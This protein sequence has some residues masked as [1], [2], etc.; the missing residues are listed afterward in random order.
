MGKKHRRNRQYQ[1]GQQQFQPSDNPQDQGEVEMQEDQVEDPE[2]SEPEGNDA[3]EV[4]D[5]ATTEPETI[6]VEE[7]VAPA[8][9]GQDV[10]IPVEVPP[11][12]HQ[13]QEQVPTPAPAVP[14]PEPE[15]PKPVPPASEVAQQVSVQPAVKSLKEKIMSADV[16]KP[17]VN[18][19]NVF[20]TRR[21]ANSV[22]TGHTA[23]GNRLLKQL[24]DY[25]ERMR[26]PT[27]DRTEN[28]NRIR[29]LQQIVNT[30][31]PTTALDI[32]TATDVVRIMFDEFMQYYGE[33][34][35]DENIFLLGNTLKG[36]AYDMD[37]I[38]MF[39]EAF[40]QMVDAIHEKKKILFD[41]NRM[42]KILRNRNVSLAMCRMRDGINSRLGV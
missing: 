41:D 40:M 35:K 20:Q 17:R 16:L 34:Y 26:T 36:T 13:P 12:V 27:R 39:I 10:E 33:V 25:R 5:G 7:P 24:T 1:F 42:H 31:C 14:S 15:P 37:K 4:T 29:L 22:A 30:A 18:P 11:V 28:M 3:Q 9:D 38:V 6:Q 32:Q 8:A 21:A 23:L 19:K 2:V